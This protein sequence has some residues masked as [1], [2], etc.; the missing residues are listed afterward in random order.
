[1]IVD[2]DSDSGELTLRRLARAGLEAKFHLGPFGSLAAFAKGEYGVVILDV[3]M[4]G[5]QGTN[6]IKGLLEQGEPAPP[7][8]MLY[9][10]LDE[11]ALRER[12]RQHGADAYLTKAA[13][14]DELVM[15]VRELLDGGATHS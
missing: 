10:S 8:I 6:L 13:S 15:L 4:P 14:R 5:L 3:M 1:L 9:S 2:D 12:A 11:A 7:R